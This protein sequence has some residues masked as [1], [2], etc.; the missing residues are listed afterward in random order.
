MLDA[1]L[2]ASKF[3]GVLVSAVSAIISTLPEKPVKPGRPGLPAFLSRKSSL[4][5]VIIGLA[6]AMVS[7][8]CET[9]KS[10][11]AAHD[12]AQREIE[13]RAAKTEILTNLLN[14]IEL[15]GRSLSYLE[16]VVGQFESLSLSISFECGT[17]DAAVHALAEYVRRTHPDDTN[18]YSRNVVGYVNVT[19]N[20]GGTDE[21]T[22]ST[23]N[24]DNSLTL[25]ELIASEWVSQQPTNTPALA[26]AQCL[27]SPSLL[28]ALFSRDN[29]GSQLADADFFAVTT[30]L[31]AA[32]L[33]FSGGHAD[34]EASLEFK[35][36]RD[37][38]QRN[39]RM[40]SISDLAS[41]SLWVQLTNCPPQ[42]S[43]ALKPAHMWLHFDKAAIYLHDFRKQDLS[44]P[45]YPLDPSLGTVDIARAAR[46]VAEARR[47]PATYAAQLPSYKD[48]ALDPW[49]AMPGQDRGRPVWPHAPLAPRAAKLKLSQN[50][51][52]P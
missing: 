41:A 46:M 14:Q 51:N 2:T 27:Q 25:K 23:L 44:P 32:P 3:A 11:N 16:R 8:L 18:V 47:V 17:N 1:F 12:A 42:C 19:N 37:A 20:E 26:L 50:F 34:V 49:L 5:W 39:F 28:I 4:R 40:S 43:L 33:L 9:V 21:V 31:A 38:W 15:Q 30:N 24:R 45:E 52:N 6:V 13:D 48:I 7:T 35:V 29:R 22:I 10:K 36:T